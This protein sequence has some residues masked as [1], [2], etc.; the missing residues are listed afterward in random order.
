MFGTKTV[1]IHVGKQQA[2][3]IQTRKIKALKIRR[4]KPDENGVREEV[5]DTTEN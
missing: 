4:E 5:M 1:R 3:T 2:D